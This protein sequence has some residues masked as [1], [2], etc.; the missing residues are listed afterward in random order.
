M[1]YTQQHKHY[2]EAMGLVPWTLRG[3]ASVA[4]TTDPVKQVDSIVADVAEQANAVQSIVEHAG[5]CSVLLVFNDAKNST[6]TLNEKDNKLLLDMF[7]AIQL[8]N[9]SVA[10]RNILVD[11]STDVSAVMEPL[12]TPTVKVILFAAHDNGGK[13]DDGEASSRLIAN[14]LSVPVWQL[15][16]PA[17]I[18]QQ[19]SLK[20]RAWNVLKAVRDQLKA[21]VSA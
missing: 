2:L 11:A 5:D 19:P 10:R 8:P 1:P 14:D 20:R 6:Q 9:A 4:V 17:S 13:S 15:P 21:P 3:G 7:A 12:L 18:Q 16:H